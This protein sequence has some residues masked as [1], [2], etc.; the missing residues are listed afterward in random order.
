MNDGKRTVKRRRLGRLAM[1]IALM[2]G[3]VFALAGTSSA[4]SDDDMASDVMQAV[5]SD[6]GVDLS[7]EM[8]HDRLEEQVVEA[9][10]A[11]ALLWETL[12]ELGFGWESSESQ[13]SATTPEASFPGEILRERLRDRIR[14]QLQIWLAIAPEWREVFEQLRERIRDCREDG[15][16]SCWSEVRLQLQYEHAQR[17]EESFEN[18]Y[19][20]MQTNGGFGVEP[21]ELERMR[22]HTQERVQA[23]IENVPPND[24]EEAGVQLQELE[25]LRERLREQSQIHASTSSSSPMSSTSTSTS[26][27]SS[28]SE[29]EDSTPGGPNTSQVGPGSTDDDRS[30]RG[31]D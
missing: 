14:E 22:E 9:I 17:F 8:V 29:P 1:L 3:L 7:D 15:G 25:R 30:G 27:P 6:Q 18:R 11:G 12:N 31:E 19:Q 5:L 4:L 21:G 10:R 2:F 23:M 20:E 13:E 28:T 24:L 16:Q 26:A